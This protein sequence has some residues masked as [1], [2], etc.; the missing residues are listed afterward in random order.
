MFLFLGRLPRKLFKLQAEYFY[1]KWCKR[2]AEPIPPEKRLKFTNPWIY[3]WMREYEVCL[4]KPNKRY[5]TD[6]NSS[7]T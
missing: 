6:Y 7:R 3:A 2:Q 4:K 5:R 1:D